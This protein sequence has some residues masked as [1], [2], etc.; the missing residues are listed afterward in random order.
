MSRYLFAAAASLTLILLGSPPAMAAHTAD[1]FEFPAS[2]TLDGVPYT[3]CSS[4]DMQVYLFLDIG[5]VALYLANCN[6]RPLLDQGRLLYF[7]YDHDFSA[8]ELRKSGRVLLKRNLS[9][10]SFFALKGAL[11]RFN[12]LYQPVKNG[13]SY[14]IGTNARGQL[15]LFLNQHYLGKS[16]SAALSAAYFK[17]WFGPNPFSDQVKNDLLY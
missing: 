3:L 2:V 9:S 10:A 14:R 15:T 12:Q 8:Q 5:D 16:D 11:V 7:Y 4:A 17:I 1:G 13:D 6:Q